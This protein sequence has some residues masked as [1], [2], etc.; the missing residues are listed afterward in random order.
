MRKP[1]LFS[2]IFALLS[3]FALI[4][5]GGGGGGEDDDIFAPT[6]TWVHKDYTYTGSDGTTSTALTCYFMFSRDGY[7]NSNLKNLPEGSQ[8]GSAT[9]IKPGLTIVIV[10]KERK[11]SSTNELI[12]AFGDKL[13]YCKTFELDKETDSG[14]TT[15]FSF[16]MT[17][18][19]WNVFYIANF[20]SLYPT[21][22]KTPPTMLTADGY[23]DVSTINDAFTKIKENFTWQK[24]LLHILLLTL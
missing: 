17:E 22:T 15:A 8:N 18:A 20:A 3:I 16:K 2:V 12:K 1:I 11:A 7:T 14:D 13:F 23:S 21:E 10:P 4:S 24:L 5:C 6:N 9:S 19:K